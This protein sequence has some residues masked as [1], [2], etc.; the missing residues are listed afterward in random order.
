VKQVQDVA[1]L[2]GLIKWSWG[3]CL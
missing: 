1:A 3:C 2:Q